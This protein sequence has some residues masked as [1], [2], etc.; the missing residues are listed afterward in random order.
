[1]KNFRMHHSGSSKYNSL[2]LL[3]LIS[4]NCHSKGFV[5]ALVPK[6]THGLTVRNI[7]GND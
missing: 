7:V 6:K 3:C 1:M 2:K 4:Q 5:T